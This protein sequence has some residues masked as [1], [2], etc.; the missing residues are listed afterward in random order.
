MHTTI[1]SLSKPDAQ[2]LGFLDDLLDALDL[3]LDFEINLGFV[4]FTIKDI[5]SGLSDLLS[6]II[7]PIQKLI[8]SLVDPIL[9]ALGFNIEINIPWPTISFPSINLPSIPDISALLVLLD[10][11][12][13]FLVSRSLIKLN[14]YAH[15]LKFAHQ[16]VLSST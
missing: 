10:W 2:I 4:S 8:N 14:I 5:F 13:H 7:A 1:N 3:I 12:I 6:V 16:M 15:T 9:N 11:D